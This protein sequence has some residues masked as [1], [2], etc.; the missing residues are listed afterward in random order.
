M[1]KRIHKLEATLRREQHTLATLKQL[2]ASYHTYEPTEALIATLFGTG[3]LSEKD[4]VKFAEREIPKIVKQISVLK[5]RIKR[6]K[7]GA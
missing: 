2:V 5:L 4:A 3:S 6:V 1:D 7:G